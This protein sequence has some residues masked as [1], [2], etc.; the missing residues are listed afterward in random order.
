MPGLQ[1]N[2]QHLHAGAMALSP[3][4]S[5]I[6]VF[7]NKHSRDLVHNEWQSESASSLSLI[8]Q[9]CLTL[10]QI[11]SILE[12]YRLGSRR[13]FTPAFLPFFS[14]RSM[15]TLGSIVYFSRHETPK[16]PIMDGNLESQ[17]SP[18]CPEWKAMVHR[19][20]SSEQWHQYLDWSCFI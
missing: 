20:F 19:N 16:F 11:P 4:P 8:P 3:Y 14:I 13:A 6:T 5:F 18:N 12:V 2:P 17:P 10:D 15:P 7:S 1:T 9:C